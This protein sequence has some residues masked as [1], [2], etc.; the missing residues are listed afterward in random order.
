MGRRI[1]NLPVARAMPEPALDPDLPILD[2]HHHL[3]DNPLHRCPVPEFADE[4]ASSGHNVRATVYMNGW[5]MY[6]ADGPEQMRP[7]GEVEF[8]NGQAAMAASGQYGPTRIAAA[9]RL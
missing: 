9:Y 8:A 5:I 6:R 7:I 4:I 2:P 3:W 1:R